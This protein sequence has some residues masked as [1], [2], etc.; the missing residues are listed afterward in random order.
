MAF[1][2]TFESRLSEK[3]VPNAARMNDMMERAPTRM[4]VLENS[5]SATNFLEFIQDNAQRLVA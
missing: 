3:I 1:G 2:P 5:Y 4:I